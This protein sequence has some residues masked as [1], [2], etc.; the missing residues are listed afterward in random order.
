M[1]QDSSL[2]VSHSSQCTDITDQ[3]SQSLVLVKLCELIDQCVKHV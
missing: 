3:H 1:S 2:P